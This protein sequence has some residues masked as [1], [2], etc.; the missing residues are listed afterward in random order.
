MPEEELP[1]PQPA[2]QPAPQ[3]ETQPEAPVPQ[4]AFN[5]LG[6]WLIR[7]TVTDNMYQPTG[8][9]QPPTGM[10]YSLMVTSEHG[11]QTFAPNYIHNLVW[12]RKTKPAPP[13]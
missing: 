5:P 13:A 7:D 9:I 6:E 8:L 10:H 4:Q 1:Q 11:V 3:P 12:I 2:A